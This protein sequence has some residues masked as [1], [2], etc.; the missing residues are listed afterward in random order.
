MTRWKTWATLV[1]AIVVPT[2]F[3]IGSV[4]AAPASK[5]S[6]PNTTST[7][8]VGKEPKPH[9]VRTK[10]KAAVD[11]L[12]TRLPAVATEH[13]LST[14]QLSTQLL[15]DSTLMVDGADRLLYVEPVNAAGA[16]T[17]GVTGAPTPT[18]GTT[19]APADAF[20]LHSKPGANRVIHLDFD[21][22]VLSRS[23]T[24]RRPL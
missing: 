14:D 12:G 8:A 4:D 16:T 3:A 13:G 24:A 2:L 18:I 22:T 19:I 9:G 10:G 21:G 1:A 6:G 5:P 23:P 17:R 20:T 11:R 15:T 7:S